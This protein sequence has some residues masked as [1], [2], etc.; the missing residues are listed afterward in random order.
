MTMAYD[1]VPWDEDNASEHGPW[2]A[3]DLDGTI[4][5]YHQWEGEL[6]IGKPIA[7]TVEL[8][9]KMVKEGCIVKIFTARLSFPNRDHDAI[10]N[11]IQD[12]LEEQGLPRLEV[13]ATKDWRFKEFYDDK[14]IAVEQNTGEMLS[15]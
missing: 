10:V 8:M 4:A 13:T 9:R 6:A 15:W 7:P 12:W 14:A 11:A 5:E 2:Y 1:Y 3:F